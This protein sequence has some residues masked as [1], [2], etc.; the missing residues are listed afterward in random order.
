MLKENLF[1]MQYIYNHSPSFL[2]DFGILC[3]HPGH[4]QAVAPPHRA[5]LQGHSYA[6]DY[7]SVSSQLLR[8]VYLVFLI[9]PEETYF[10]QSY[11]CNSYG[12]ESTVFNLTSSSIRVI[13]NYHLKNN[14]SLKKTFLHPFQYS[15]DVAVIFKKSKHL[16]VA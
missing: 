9:N 8:I 1:K 4:P 15:I 3:L 6:T 5:V 14:F 13:L 16:V 12:T 10:I 2:F 11:K 7:C